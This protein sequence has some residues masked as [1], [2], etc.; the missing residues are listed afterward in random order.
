M[1]TTAEAAKEAQ[2]R[3]EREAKARA[4]VRL[5]S[6]HI[7]MGHSLSEAVR[8]SAERVLPME[9]IGYM[10]VAYEGVKDREWSLSE[11]N[12]LAAMVGRPLLPEDYLSPTTPGGVDS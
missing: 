9:T 3:R 2:E 6:Y 10:A 11:H 1:T 4:A 8:A 7:E 12:R 5:A